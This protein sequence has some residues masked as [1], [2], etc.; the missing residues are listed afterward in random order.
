MS[1]LLSPFVIWLFPTIAGLGLNFLSGKSRGKNA[2][3]ALKAAA[4]GC[5]LL[6]LGFFCVL[7]PLPPPIFWVVNLLIWLIPSAISFIVAANSA[8]KEMRA[9]RD[10]EFTEAA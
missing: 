6:L 9:Q 3:N 7:G 5:W 8:L 1:W 4:W 10:G 2:K